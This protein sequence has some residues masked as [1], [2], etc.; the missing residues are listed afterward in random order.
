[1]R[2]L[3]LHDGGSGCAFYRVRLPMEQL[4]LH[5][6]EVRLASGTEEKP[7]TLS[8]MQGWDVIVSQRQLSHK[9]LESWRRA[10]GP[11]SRLVYETDDDVFTIRPD[12][13]QAYWLYSKEDIRDTVT[14][15]AEVAD[16]ITVTTPY[17]AGVMRENTGNLNIAVLPNS[18]PAWVLDMP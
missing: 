13:F 12:N 9:S 14:H 3:A 17:L 1:M 2:I 5:G 11:F 16:L 8:D 6:H 15:G 10:R 7:V 4:A 18:V